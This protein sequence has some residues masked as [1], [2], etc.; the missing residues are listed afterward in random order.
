MSEWKSVPEEV[1][2]HWSQIFKQSREGL[3]VMGACP[4]CSREDLHR[5]FDASHLEPDESFG[6]E[7]A[8]RGGQWQWC[9]GCH[10]YEHMSGRVPT[11]WLGSEGSDLQVDPEELMH[12]PDVIEQARV[13]AS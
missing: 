5:W 2:E 9:A 13:A 10:S 12:D 1:W 8:G 4:V 11:W 6:E 7:M 3:D